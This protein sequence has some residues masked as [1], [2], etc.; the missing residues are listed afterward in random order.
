M[1]KGIAFLHV[2]PIICFDS[3]L[4]VNETVR[5]NQQLYRLR[6]VQEETKGEKSEEELDSRLICTFYSFS[7]SFFFTS[8]SLWA[9]GSGPWGVDRDCIPGSCPKLCTPTLEVSA[10]FAAVSLMASETGGGAEG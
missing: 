6:L 8:F 10:S 1:T 5:E 4:G 7:V 3:F 2:H 9:R